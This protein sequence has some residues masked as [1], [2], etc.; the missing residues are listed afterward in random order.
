MCL[1]E[2]ILDSLRKKQALILLMGP[3]FF[4]LNFSRSFFMSVAAWCRAVDTVKNAC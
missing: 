1:E 2:E 3:G 4:S